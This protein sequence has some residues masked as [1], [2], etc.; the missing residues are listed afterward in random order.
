MTLE[1]LTREQEEM[2]SLTVDLYNEGVTNVMKA[3]GGHGS[4]TYFSKDGKRALSHMGFGLEDGTEE[5]WIVEVGIKPEWMIGSNKYTVEVKKSWHSHEAFWEDII[6][7]DS[8]PDSNAVIVNHRHYYIGNE[9]PKDGNGFRGFGG[10]LFQWRWLD[11]MSAA[12]QEAVEAPIRQS[13]NMWYQ[14]IIPPKFREALPDNAVWV[15][16]DLAFPFTD[17]KQPWQE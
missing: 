7:Q 2:R 14:G 1:P 9:Y 17:V 11:E 6:A 8:K 13:T 15:D 5:I 10:R 16:T 3:G 12:Y 4:Q